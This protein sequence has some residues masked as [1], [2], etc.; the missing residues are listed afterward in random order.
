MDITTK[1]DSFLNE[2]QDKKKGAAEAAE[3]QKVWDSPK[4]APTTKH[5]PLIWEGILGTMYA[6]N[7]D[8]EGYGYFKI[9]YFDYDYEAA[10]KF[11][12]INECTDLRKFKM[13]KMRNYSGDPHKSPRKGQMVLWGVWS[14]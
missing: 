5:I 8:K 1:I 7:P 9:K 6:M 10:M 2:A 13:D 3:F 12:K 4:K 11:A 14:K